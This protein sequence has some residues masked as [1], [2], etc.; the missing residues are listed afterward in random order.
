MSKK[1][2]YTVILE[3]NEAKG[4]SFCQVFWA[5]ANDIGEAIHLVCRESKFHGIKN[6]YAREID[7]YD[8]LALPPDVLEGEVEGTYYANK[9]YHYDNEGTIILPY[10]IIESCIEG[11]VFIEEVQEGFECYD[12]E[13]NTFCTYVVLDRSN[14]K[15]CF[16]E[17][18]KS[19]PSIKVSWIVVSKE[20][21]DK[22]E[23]VFWSNEK[24]SSIES[25]LFLLN[26]KESILENGLVKL[27]IYSDEGATNLSIDFHKTV[28]VL[29]KSKDLHCHLR[30]SL[31]RLG[32]SENSDIKSIEFGMHHWHYIP[33]GAPSRCIFEQFLRD[34]G[35]SIW[36]TET[37]SYQ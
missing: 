3:M 23:E 16:I 14:L 5:W 11:D 9:K 8:F 36:K 21:E 4:K 20:W 35:F 30:K 28:K 32:I 31:L 7:P 17:M 33:Y 25:V 22:S 12:N 27:T 6:P 2:F 18:V 29:T 15:K 10:G 24:F 37:V 1:V 13:D 19:L 34:K 26:Q